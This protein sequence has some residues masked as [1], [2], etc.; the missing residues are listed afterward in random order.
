MTEPDTSNSLN[1]S[2]GFAASAAWWPVPAAIAWIIHP[3]DEVVTFAGGR[4]QSLD[5]GAICWLVANGIAESDFRAS[6]PEARDRLLDAIRAGDVE[7]RGAR[8]RRIHSGGSTVETVDVQRER[9]PVDEATGLEF[10]VDCDEV[11][12]MPSDWRVAHGSDWRNARGWSAVLVS[13]ADLRRQFNAPAPVS[14][15]PNAAAFVAGG[16]AQRPEGVGPMAIADAAAWIA[17]TSSSGSVD[18]AEA[19]AERAARTLVDHLAAGHLTAFG[20]RGAGSPVEIEPRHWLGLDLV[21]PFGTPPLSNIMGER[22]AFFVGS[23]DLLVGRVSVDP[24]F[25]DIV[26]QR[27]DVA[28]LWPPQTSPRAEATRAEALP[29]S[30]GWRIDAARAAIARLWPEGVPRNIPDKEIHRRVLADLPEHERGISVDT[31]RR[32]AG[33]KR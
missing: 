8:F 7:A 29:S 4:S 12:L 26:V 1:G 9:V 3:R 20:L 27:E 5:G 18:S 33:R 25:R 15:S 32:A 14:G 6:V 13:S 21:M 24:P 2:N 19:V 11:R 22:R 31:I 28:R 17:H 10:A 30:R 23:G 16:T